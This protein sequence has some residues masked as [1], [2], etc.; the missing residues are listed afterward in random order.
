[1]YE[2][3]RCKKDGNTNRHF[4]LAEHFATHNHAGHDYW[5]HDKLDERLY[6]INERGLTVPLYKCSRCGRVV[7]KPEGEYYCKVCGPS[8]KMLK[9]PEFTDEVFDF[10]SFED[11]VKEGYVAHRKG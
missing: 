8:A 4:S 6:C 2:Y 10:Q 5:R 1:M 9:A 11:A 7:E 3:R